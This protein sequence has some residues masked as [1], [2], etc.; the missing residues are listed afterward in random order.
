MTTLES[1]PD[2]PPAAPPRSR[3]VL[4]SVLHAREL[5]VTVA[6]IALV[7]FTTLANPLFLSAQGVKD[8]LLNSTIMVILAIGQAVVIISRNVDLSVG[9]S[10][11]LVA[12]MTGTVFAANP[13][14]PIIVVFLI[15]IAFGAVLGAINGLLVTVAKV[16]ALVITLGTMYIYRGVNNAWA[17]GTQ[18]FADDRPQ[19]FG[20]LSVDTFLGLPI[21]TLIAIAVLIVVAIYMSGT[22]SG[23]DLYAI[24]SDPDAAKVFGIKISKRVFF[25][26]LVNG[27]L[28]GL[29]GVLYAS[30]FN[31]VGASTGYGMELDVVAAAVVGG[32]AI[33]GGS[34]TVTGAAIGAVLLTTITS[35]LTALRVDK[36]WQQAIVGVL[37]VTSIV[38][39]RVASARTAKRRRESEARDV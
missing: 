22:R 36:F 25:A 10:L 2:S 18:Y 39:D 9:S 14:M 35:A 17:G 7:V 27:A 20:A 4:S 15:G 8:L 33:F 11:G 5:P 3:S 30:R 12:F 23:R 13:D 24:G 37:I 16:P 1:P 29:A 19:S 34:G 38:I 6:L 32:V 28:A 31:S 26:F 21:I